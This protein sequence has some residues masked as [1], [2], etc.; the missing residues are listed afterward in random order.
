M[1]FTSQSYAQT[2][3][4]VVNAFATAMKK[5]LTYAQEH[6]DE[7]RAILSSYLKIDPA[8][9]KAMTLPRWTP[10]LDTASVQKL[11]DLSKQDGLIPTTPDLTALLP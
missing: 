1:Y 2:N 3:P 4:A 5:S 8:V 9:Q 7:A 6:P 11:A 10:D